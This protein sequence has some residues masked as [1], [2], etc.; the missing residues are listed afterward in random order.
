M[1][2]G[3]IRDEWRINAIEDKANRAMYKAN[4]L[5][6]LR[7]NVDSLERACR[8]FRTEVDGLRNELQSLKDALRQAVEY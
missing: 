6:A 3:Y 8:E 4:E 2:T 7:S 5:D 1:Q